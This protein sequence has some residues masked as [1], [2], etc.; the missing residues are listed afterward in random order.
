MSLRIAVLAHN[1]LLADGIASRLRE[2]GGPLE[3]Q[4]VAAGDAD[5]PQRLQRARPAIV[6]MDST[7]VE[8]VERMPLE[9]LWALLPEA[10]VVRLDPASDHVRVF[11]CERRRAP[12][13]ESL[14]AAI[15]QI[16]PAGCLAAAGGTLAD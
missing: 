14:I 7:D 3:V 16:G 9:R 8:A 15:L 4:A 2:H 6:L 11:C 13:I 5:L 1:S 12:G 10:R